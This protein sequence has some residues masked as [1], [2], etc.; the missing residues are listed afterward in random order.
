MPYSNTQIANMALAHLGVSTEIATLDTDTTKEAKVCR[1]FFTL[2]QERCLRDFSW[3]FAM[4]IATLSEIEA[5][6][7]DEW[8]YSYQYPTDCANLKRILSGT[9]TD[10]NDTRVAFRIANDG[11]NKIIFTDEAEAQAEYTVNLDETA[12]FPAD[13]VSALSYLLAFYVAVPVT[14]GDPFKLGPRAMSAYEHEIENAQA[15]A[16]N[17]EQPDVQP[18]SEFERGR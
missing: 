2:A 17:E 16:A 7:N 4:K 9:R 3:P 5:D 8:G 10:T 15:N 14:G 1:R 11:T 12:L 13:F 18:D 6:P